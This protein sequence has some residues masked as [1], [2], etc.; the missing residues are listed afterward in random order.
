MRDLKGSDKE[1][2]IF[3]WL[4]C[5]DLK[6]SIPKYVLNT[7]SIQLVVIISKFSPRLPVK[8]LTEFMF[9]VQ[10]S[11]NPLEIESCN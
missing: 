9:T 4:L 2:C 10:K 7:V 5:L 6:G 11:R 8:N 3:E 1:N